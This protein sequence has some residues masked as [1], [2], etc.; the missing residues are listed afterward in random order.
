MKYISIDIETSGLD[1]AN[2]QILSIAA[3]IEDTEN[4]KPI[5]DIPYIHLGLLR[6]NISGSVFAIDMNR[7]LIKTINQY[8]T[9]DDEDRAF[10]SHV[11]GMKFVEEKNVVKELFKFFLLNG[12]EYDDKNNLYANLKQDVTPVLSGNMSKMYLNAAGKNFGTFDKIFLEKLPHWKQVFKVRSRI[13]DPT[14][15]CVNWK[16]DTQLPSLSECK[17]RVGLHEDVSH[18]AYEDA[19][20]VI[21]VLRSITQNYEKN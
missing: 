7:D 17:Q 10:I 21:C 2:C 3:V 16:T 20:D 19:L 11:T 18:N 8:Q 4:I 14:T 15:L 1:D 6:E 12:V 5:N 13:I 9:S